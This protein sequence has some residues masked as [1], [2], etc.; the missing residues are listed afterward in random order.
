MIDQFNTEFNRDCEPMKG[1]YTDNYYYQMV[2]HIRRFKGMTPPAKVSKPKTVTV[3]GKFSEWSNVTPVFKDAPGDVINRDFQNVNN[4]E[5]YVNNTARN[6]IIESRVTYDE[7]NVYFYVKTLKAMTPYTDKNWMTLF[8]DTDRNKK[9]GWE[10]YDWVV[11]YKV[12]SA[13]KT[14]LVGKGRTFEVAYSQKG[15]QMEIAIPRTPLGMTDTVPAFCFHWADN[16][17]H[18]KDV[19]AF[20]TD[21]ESAPDRRFDYCFAP[22]LGKHAGEE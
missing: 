4:S 6:D 21:G 10:G 1:G 15:E 16:M 3:D 7:K 12:T 19:T 20:F 22:G 2:A 8:I 5:R 11:N 18:T 9:T 17:Q 14:T 13:D